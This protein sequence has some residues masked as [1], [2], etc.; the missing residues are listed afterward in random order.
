MGREVFRPQERQ[1]SE[2]RECGGQK[3]HGGDDGWE[4]R[5]GDGSVGAEDVGE[6]DYA[7]NRNERH[8]GGKQAAGD[9]G[10]AAR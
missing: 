5:R 4:G 1:R 10:G 9:A 6:Q 3:D 8:P 7:G 2:Q